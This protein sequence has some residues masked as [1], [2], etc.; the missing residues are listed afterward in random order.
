METMIAEMTTSLMRTVLHVASRPAVMQTSV[1]TMDDAFLAAGSVTSMMIARI[2]PMRR[3]VVS[4]GK[5]KK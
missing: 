2:A 4:D 5:R 1:V 3:I